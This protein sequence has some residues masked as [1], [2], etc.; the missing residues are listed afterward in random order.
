[1]K[2]IRNFLLFTAGLCMSGI[3]TMAMK[4]KKIVEP[5]NQKKEKSKFILTLLD[6]INEILKKENNIYESN[7]ML[8][9]TKEYFEKIKNKQDYKYTKG[10][11][12]IIKTNMNPSKYHSSC[13]K[14]K[15]L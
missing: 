11:I 7:R 1:M 9:S 5:Q 6:K 8:N 2:N 10:E 14:N 13:F 15:Y 3:P 4:E 12:N